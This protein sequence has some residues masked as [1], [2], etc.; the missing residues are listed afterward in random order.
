MP[1]TQPQ[2]IVPPSEEVQEYEYLHSPNYDGQGKSLSRE[3][4]DTDQMLAVVLLSCIVGAALIVLGA[5][6]LL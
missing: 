6:F 3:I 1:K 2:P 5:A 4:H